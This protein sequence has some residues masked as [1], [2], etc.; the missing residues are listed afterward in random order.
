M[1]LGRNAGQLSPKKSSFSAKCRSNITLCEFTLIELLIVIAI[2]AILASLLLP[3]L[4]GA[5]K[6]AVSILCLSNLKQMG[7]SLVQYQDSFSDY[8]PMPYY[9]GITWA[10]QLKDLTEPAS[11]KGYQ[12]LGVTDADLARSIAMSYRAYRC[13]GNT[14][15]LNDCAGIN[16]EVYGMNGC[17]GGVWVQW[18]NIGVWSTPDQYPWSKVSQIGAHAATTNVPM[19]SPSSTV[20]L[21]DSDTVSTYIANGPLHDQVFYF[22]TFQ[23]QI[24]LRHGT[25]ANTLMLDGSARGMTWSDLTVSANCVSAVTADFNYLER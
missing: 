9:N 23:N 16:R 24:I 12:W 21:A 19:K 5:K 22:C 6:R 13:P 25:T 20:I 10:Y 14:P 8:Y 11:M 7:A 18:E 4:N 15:G 3:A 1:E 2:I 17:L